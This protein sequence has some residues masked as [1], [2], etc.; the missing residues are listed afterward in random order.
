[1]GAILREVAGPHVVGAVRTQP[2][3][4][5]D[6]EPEPG[7]FGLLAGDFQPLAPPDP[8]HPLR[9]HMPAGVVQQAGDPAVAVA[10]MVL[11]QRDD[12]LGEE[13]LVR[14]AA[15]NPTLGGAMPA[16]RAAGAALGHAGG[17]PHAV[18]AS[19]ATRRARK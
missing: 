7:P 8:F 6:G 16:R 15:R 10:P 3:A 9:I 2:D 19:T 4:G 14:T 12:V 5:A 13:I 11:R 17:L 18:D 1:M